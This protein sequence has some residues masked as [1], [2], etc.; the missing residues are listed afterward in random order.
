MI[1]YIEE[2]NAQGNVFP[3]PYARTI[4]PLA[5]PGT[6]GT[7]HIWLATDE[8]QPCNSSDPHLHKDQEEVLFFISGKGRVRIDDEEINVGPGF[9]VLLP[10]GGVHQVF[11]DGDTIL[12]FLAVVSP[13]FPEK[14][15]NP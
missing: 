4:I 13:P 12:R 7:K 2:K 3:K 9:C 1:H 14:N 8:I 10:I 15:P 5:S 6:L 11:N